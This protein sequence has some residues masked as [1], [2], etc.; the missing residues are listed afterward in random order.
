MK[1]CVS[2]ID[3]QGNK[4]TGYY[5]LY[6]DRCR[7]EDGPVQTICLSGDEGARGYG[8]SHGGPSY[9]DLVDAIVS[10]EGTEKI[11]AARGGITKRHA[12]A[13]AL[14]HVEKNGQEEALRRVRVAISRLGAADCDDALDALDAVVDDTLRLQHEAVDEANALRVERDKARCGVVWYIARPYY[15]QGDNEYFHAADTIDTETLEFFE[16]ESDALFHAAAGGRVKLKECLFYDSL[17]YH[18]PVHITDELTE[19][20][21]DD[22]R[23]ILHGDGTVGTFHG[24]KTDSVLCSPFRHDLTDEECDAVLEILPHLKMMVGS[25][26]IKR[27]S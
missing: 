10:V 11:L 9:R 12:V 19:A 15:E 8:Y 26:Q 21:Y 24:G 18:C 17:C 27:A 14:K 5:C 22:L 7:C 1:N 6:T 3:G 20:N 13:T 23:R 25:A 2:Y 4:K 16:S